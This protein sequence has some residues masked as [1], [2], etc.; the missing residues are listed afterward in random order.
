MSSVTNELEHN[1]N[2]HHHVIDVY[3]SEHLVLACTAP[4]HFGLNLILL[5]FSLKKMPDLR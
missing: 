4:S 1:N 5:G 3:R 2:N